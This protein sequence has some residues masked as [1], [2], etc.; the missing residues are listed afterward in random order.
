[1]RECFPK[2]KP[3]QKIVKIELDLS[4]C[5]TKADLKNATGIDTSKFA[6]HKFPVT[7]HNFNR[8]TLETFSA[9]L[10]QA[11]LATKADI[12]EFIENTE[13][14]DTPNNLNKKFT[15]IKIKHAEAEK[16][17]I[18]LTNKVVHISEKGYDFLLGKMYFT[19]GNGYENFFIFCPNAYFNNVG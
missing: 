16:K 9:R 2:P 4:S 6:T 8:I 10:K 12:G 11:N 15:S 18:D 3:L 7:T 19:G 13:F 14:D 5:A 1:M 17:L